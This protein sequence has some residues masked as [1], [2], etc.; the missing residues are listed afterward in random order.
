[1]GAN[2]Y[3]DLA[4]FQ[5]RQF[6][7]ALGPLVAAGQDFQHHPCGFGQGLQPRQMLARQNFRRGHHHPLPARFNRDQQ[8]HQ[9][10]QRFARPH[11]ALQQPVHP[12]GTGHVGFDFLDRTGLCARWLVRQ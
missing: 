2:Q 10:H 4:R 8:S 3:L 11:I 1:M 5:R 7:R 6:R 9:S 12:F